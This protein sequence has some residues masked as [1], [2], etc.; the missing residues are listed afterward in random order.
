M[1]RRDSGATAIAA[2]TV[3]TLEP[4]RAQPGAANRHAVVIGMD[5]PGTSQD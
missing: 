5:K 4:V 3:M 1:K 2:A